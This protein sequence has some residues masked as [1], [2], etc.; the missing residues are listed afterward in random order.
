MLD[1]NNQ[2]IEEININ[3]ENGVKELIIRKGDAPP[4]KEP[5]KYKLNDVTFDSLI[6]YVENGLTKN[7]TIEKE[8]A[9]AV[10]NEAKGTIKFYADYKNED[11][12]EVEA[13]LVKSEY[14][15]RFRINK[16]D[17]GFN[18]KDIFKLI[19]FNNRFISSPDWKDILT[20]ISS[21]KA[22]QVRKI[23]HNL[24]DQRGNAKASVE[25]QNNIDFFEEFTLNIPIFKNDE[26]SKFTVQ[27]LI[28]VVNNDMFFW[29]E[30]PALEEIIETTISNTLI[31]YSKKLKELGLT[32]LA[33]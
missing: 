16:S 7:N 18:R 3:V 24:K 31:E 11:S 19:Q 25:I 26:S 27:I 30:S 2:N 23:E 28:D 12:D 14:L 9:L 32:C 13:K 29:L 4:V 1:N 20:K 33:M 5:V 21:V 15:D 6:E 10:V 8:K 17:N 22:E